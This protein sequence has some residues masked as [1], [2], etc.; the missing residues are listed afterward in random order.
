[1][2]KELKG[3]DTGVSLMDTEDLPDRF[4]EEDV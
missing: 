1:M 4:E 3:W 2:Q